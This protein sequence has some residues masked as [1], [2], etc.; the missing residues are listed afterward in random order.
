MEPPDDEDIVCP[1]C[2]GA[3]EQTSRD[4]LKCSD[5]G[6]SFENVPDIEPEVSFY[7]EKNLP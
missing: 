6:W 3:A 4:E 2:G 5:C 1:E 7:N